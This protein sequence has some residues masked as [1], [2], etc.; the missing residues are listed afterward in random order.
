[1]LNQSSVSNCNPAFLNTYSN[2]QNYKILLQGI[3]YKSTQTIIL[4][5]I[6]T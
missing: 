6:L 5:N 3:S 2:A 4:D 1:M